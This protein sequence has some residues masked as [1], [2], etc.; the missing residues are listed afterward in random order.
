MSNGQDGE[1][2]HV[3]FDHLSYLLI[4]DVVHAIVHTIRSW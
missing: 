3:G 1:A 2:L 4:C